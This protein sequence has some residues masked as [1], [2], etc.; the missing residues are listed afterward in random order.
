MNKMLQRLVVMFGAPDHTDPKKFFEEL[1]KLTDNFSEKELDK[2]ADLVIREHKGRSFPAVSAVLDA[3]GRAR[4]MLAPRQA[5]EP[6]KY[7]E[8]GP[9]AFAYAAGALKTEIG[10]QAAHEG[11]VL[12]LHQF[13]RENRRQPRSDEIH[14]LKV[15]ARGFDEAYAQVCSGNGGSLSASLK[16][17]GE[18]MLERRNRYARIACDEI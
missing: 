18:T 17:W 5:F 6:P 2:A 14:D 16:N 8:W 3:C 15:R 11:W 9:A 13:L 4:E 12:S 1:S 7:P 10:R